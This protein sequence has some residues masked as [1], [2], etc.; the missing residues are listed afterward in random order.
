MEILRPTLITSV[1][2]FMDL[3][4]TL[5]ATKEVVTTK[6]D[7]WVTKCIGGA[8]VILVEKTFMAQ[9]TTWFKQ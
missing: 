5:L 2:R 4:I 3:I 6:V 1:D 8:T 7:V 9:T